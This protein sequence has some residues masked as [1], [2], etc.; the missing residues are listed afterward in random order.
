VRPP[1]SK[2]AAVFGT[3]YTDASKDGWGATFLLN[4]GQVL[5]AGAPWAKK[6]HYE[7]NAAETR[8]VANALEAFQAHLK[9]GAAIA[10]RIDNTS[11]E[12]GIKKGH[13]ASWGEKFCLHISLL[14]SNLS[15]VLFLLFP[16]PRKLL[17]VYA[18]TKEIKDKVEKE[19]PHC[20]HISFLLYLHLSVAGRE[21]SP[22]LS[23]RRS[24]PCDPVIPR[25]CGAK[26]FSLEH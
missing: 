11:A 17:L 25:L 6:Y 1:T 12:A 7:V 16:Y 15:L 20:V 26:N 14:P 5:R 13:S 10:L 24:P 2:K 23:R 22:N 9:R 19:I 8:A 18:N 3:L 4:S 21:S